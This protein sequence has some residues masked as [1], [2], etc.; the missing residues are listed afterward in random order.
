MNL[1]LVLQA[2]Y[3]DPTSLKNISNLPGNYRVV[4]TLNKPG[5]A[6]VNDGFVSPSQQLSGDSHLAIAAPALVSTDGKELDFDAIRLDVST[7]NGSF[8]FKG[9]PN[10]KGF[11]GKIETE[12]FHAEHF[13]NAALLALQA[14]S[15][16][17]SALSAYHDVPVHIYQMDVVE[18]RTNTHQISFRSPFKDKMLWMPPLEN[19][20]TEQQKY[21]SLYREAMN[22]TSSN[23]TFLCFYRLIEGLRNRREKIRKDEV[24]AAL[25]KQEKPVAQP[26]E[27]IPSERDEQRAWL[28]ALYAA[29]QDWDDLALEAIF[30]EEAVGRRVR[31]LIDKGQEL[32][33]LRNKISH[34]VLESGE[35]VISIDNALDI[36]LVEKWLPI[37]KFIARYLLN[38]CFPEFLKS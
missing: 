14:F 16:T 15:P 6:P 30:I 13:G 36:E 7:A 11:L 31:N 28:N 34:A 17:L 12:P 21:A 37:C 24:N 35:E 27:R 19:A 2:G 5:Y 8:V 18:L 20:A 1:K 23:Y 10:D 26:D 29:P 4:F 38:D 25:A 9:L 32:H 3:S 33:E 22:S